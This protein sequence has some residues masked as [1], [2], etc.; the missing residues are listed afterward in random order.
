[1]IAEQ[2]WPAKVDAQRKQLIIRIIKG[3]PFFDIKKLL[4]ANRYGRDMLQKM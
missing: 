4:K 2:T 3:S 1:M